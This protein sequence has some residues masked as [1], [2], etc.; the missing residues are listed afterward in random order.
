[1]VWVFLFYFLRMTFTST[2]F[3]SESMNQRNFVI[4]VNDRNTLSFAPSLDLFKIPRK[5]IALLFLFVCSALKSKYFCSLN[6]L[7]R[8]QQLSTVKVTCSK[9]WTS[10]NDQICGVCVY[11][12][13]RLIKHVISFFYRIINYCMHFLISKFSEDVDSF[14]YYFF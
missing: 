5:R 7:D 14:F 11:L 10:Q 2:T 6:S 8:G 4:K 12:H 3:K 13:Q 9:F 1:M